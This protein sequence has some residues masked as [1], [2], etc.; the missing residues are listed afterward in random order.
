ME[1]FVSYSLKEAHTPTT[2]TGLL[3]S[4]DRFTSSFEH[5]KKW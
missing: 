4:F 5:E 3:R 2:Q 1:W